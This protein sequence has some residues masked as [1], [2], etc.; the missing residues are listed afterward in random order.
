MSDYNQYHEWKSW[1]LDFTY[2]D[3]ELSYFTDELR[4]LVGPGKRIAEIGFG[5]GGFLTWAKERGAEVYG[6][7]IQDDI[8]RAAQ[9]HGFTAVS[10]ID[11]LA[12]YRQDGFDSIIALDVFEHIPATDIPGVLTVIRA[13]LKPNGTLY[14]RVPNGISPFGLNNQH[15]DITHVTVV[16]AAKMSQWALGTGMRVTGVHNARAVSGKALSYRIAKRIQYL[17]RDCVN[18]FVAKLYGFSTT[19]LDN[20]IAITLVAEASPTDTARPNA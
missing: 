9:A 14:L 17:M 16:S 18:V 3:W 8:V 15:G 19:A 10:R 20:N 7:E 12:A 4:P 13:L 6:V 2:N 1:E 11:D 5:N